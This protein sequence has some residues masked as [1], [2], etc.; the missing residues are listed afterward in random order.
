MAQTEDCVNEK[1]CK[2]NI[3]AQCTIYGGYY[4]WGEI[5]EYS[6]SSSFQDICPAGWH[7]A[8]S[9]EWDQLIQANMGNGVAGGF[10]KDNFSPTGFH[11]IPG[12]I[13]YLNDTW[14]FTSGMLAAT[15]Y[16]TSD[17][18]TGGY[19]I[20]RGLNSINPSVSFYASSRANALSVRC[21]RN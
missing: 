7:I 6:E 13:F 16:W 21:V 15:M 1:Y 11:G 12:G 5:M 17:G 19:A 20:A 14:A 18:L 8:T 4:Q 10:L 3:D 9:G 2:D